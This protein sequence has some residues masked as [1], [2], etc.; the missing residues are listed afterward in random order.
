[1]LPHRMYF[2]PFKI[3]TQFIFLSYFFFQERWRHTSADEHR[4]TFED[5]TNTSK[6]GKF[7]LKDNFDVN[8]FKILEKVS[9]SN[10]VFWATVTHTKNLIFNQSEDYYVSFNK[11]ILK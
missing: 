1:M 8:D 10:F 3:Q 2:N 4:E 6:S 5:F 11:Y 9:N 7:K